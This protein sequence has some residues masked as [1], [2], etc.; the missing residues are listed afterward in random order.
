MLIA[1]QLP[2]KVSKGVAGKLPA[3]P[4]ATLA[5]HWSPVL[6]SNSRQDDSANAESFV[7][8]VFR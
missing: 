8:I 2:K 1:R 6:R 7:R 4:E 5:S 3:T